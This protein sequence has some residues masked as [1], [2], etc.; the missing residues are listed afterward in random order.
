MRK[1]IE[2]LETIASQIQ[3][4][5]G[6][7][8]IKRGV[9]DGIVNP[10]EYFNAPY[11]ILWILIEPYG[12]DGGWSITEA[13]NTYNS[14]NEIRASHKFHRQIIYTTYGI[15]SNTFKKDM[16]NIYDPQVFRTL[17]QF[18]Y[19]N[20]KTVTEPTDFETTQGK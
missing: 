15:L 19:I 11:K 3:N 20:L 10:D 12:D 13:F 9:S 4:T 7:D 8:G 2:A 5:F 1:N 18:A 14:W 6:E 17:K 16:P